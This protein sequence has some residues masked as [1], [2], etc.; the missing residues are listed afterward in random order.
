MKYDQKIDLH[1]IFERTVDVHCYIIDLEV[2]PLQCQ[3]V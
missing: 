2:N 3:F 1:N